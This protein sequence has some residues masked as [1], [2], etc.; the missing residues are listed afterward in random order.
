MLTS[1]SVNGR[2][3]S[4]LGYQERRKLTAKPCLKVKILRK[5]L[6]VGFEREWSLLA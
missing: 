3:K 1:G 5:M 2:E 6:A 4:V